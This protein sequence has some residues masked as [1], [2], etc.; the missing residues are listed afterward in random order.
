[1]KEW[2]RYTCVRFLPRDDEHDAHYV[3][4]IS[5][6]GYGVILGVCKT[7]L[8]TTPLK[9]TLSSFL[10]IMSSKLTIAQIRTGSSDVESAFHS[11]S[12]GISGKALNDLRSER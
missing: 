7:R 1:M 8:D 4:I 10:F 12:A 9:A 3:R 5:G 2:E 11:A 6:T